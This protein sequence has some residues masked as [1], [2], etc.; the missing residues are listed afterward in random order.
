MIISPWRVQLLGGLSARK[1]DHVVTRFRSART[2]ALFAYLAF[3]AHRAH[4]REEL[5][6]LFWPDADTEAGRASLRTALSSLRR[7][8]EPPGVEMEAGDVLLAD[9]MYVR[10]RPEAVQT[11]AAAFEAALHAVERARDDEGKIT[12]LQ[13]AINAYAGPLLPGYYDDWLIGERER[14]AQ[15]FQTALCRLAR[16][17]H[18]NGRGE[19]A[20]ALARHAVA[21]DAGNEEASHLLRQI[22]AQ[23]EQP[24]APLSAPSRSPTST[25]Q[26]VPACD[27]LPAPACHA[28]PVPPCDAPPAPSDPPGARIPLPFT[29]FYGRESEREQLVAALLAA[30]GAQREAENGQTPRLF[31][32]T[33][34]GGIGKT[35]FA[36]EAG[37]QA[38]AQGVGAVAFVPLADVTRPDQV[39]K[40]IADALELPAVGD[41]AAAEQ[42]R[43]ALRAAP[44]LL[45]LDNFEQ[46]LNDTAREFSHNAPAASDSAPQTSRNA[47]VDAAVDAVD[48]AVDKEACADGN[49]ERQ[50]DM[51]ADL[52]AVTLITG[53]CQQCPSLIALITSRQRLNVA[54]EQEF[55]LPPLPAPQHPGTVERLLEF[56]SVR[57]FVDRARA[58]RPDFQITPRSGEDIAA[59][60]RSLEGIPLALELMAAWAQTLTPAQMRRQLA[61]RRDLLR[62]RQHGVPSRHRSLRACVEWSCRM[63]PAPLQTFFARLSVFRGGWM[64][65]AA[66]AVCEEPRF[67]EYLAE[68]R[69]RSLIVAEEVGGGLSTEESLS[70]EET[71]V[72]RCRMPETLREYAWEQLSGTERAE[73]ERRHAAYFMEAAETIRPRLSGIAQ[74]SWLNALERERDN[75]RAAL[76]NCLIR[77]AADSPA[78]PVEMA[79]LGLRLCIALQEFWQIRGGGQEGRCF[80]RGGTGADGN[81]R[82]GRIARGGFVCHRPEF[83]RR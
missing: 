46:L 1:A 52:A 75:L 25:S 62:S 55:A 68:L 58:A 17:L 26:A 74:R 21:N 71:G 34:M 31:T 37:R 27:T 43:A 61:D 16:T 39:V 14:L 47:A 30:R 42:V 5:I 70:G 56:A 7:Q 66:Q 36:I 32:I 45:I 10:L 69:E 80:F 15:A 28:S 23:A 73:C 64:P 83:W 48:A 40:A 72:M 4:P 20:A 6:E 51:P 50:D 63:L 19:E 9:R 81:T 13:A 60:C 44:L 18:Q 82:A 29:R 33:G 57:L 3:H 78:V 79:S 77:S 8:L 24:F 38:A 11:D 49:A 2:G 12:A 76:T 65:E 54:G 53:L 22:S 67:L 59:L 41:K 35:R